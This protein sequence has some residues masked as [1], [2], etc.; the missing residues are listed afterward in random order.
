ML[1]YE[2]ETTKVYALGNDDFSLVEKE[3]KKIVKEK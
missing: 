1:E 2:L 3:Y